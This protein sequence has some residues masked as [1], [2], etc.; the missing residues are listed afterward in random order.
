METD[1]LGSGWDEG[2]DPAAAEEIQ[3]AIEAAAG[4]PIPEAGPTAP[5]VADSG[6]DAPQAWGPA[7]GDGED[8]AAGADHALSEKDAAE[9]LVDILS[10]SP[11]Y[12][13]EGKLKVE[14]DLAEME[15]W[16]AQKR[17]DAS[18]IIGQITGR[19][20]NVQLVADAL[21]L[22]NARLEALMAEYEETVAQAG[23]DEDAE[24]VALAQEIQVLHAK[25]QDLTEQYIRLEGLPVPHMRGP[26]SD[27]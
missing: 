20:E 25:I 7:A 9:L 27:L 16:D 12:V 15:R 26:H 17:Q 3:G 13:E 4:I 10:K 14:P 5:E 24:V 8:P 6:W 19:P 21:E 18:D 23:N 22:E 2:T 11:V 1:W